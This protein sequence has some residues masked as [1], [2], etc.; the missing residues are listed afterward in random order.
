[1]DVMGYDRFGPYTVFECLGAGGMAS[2]H[3]A[4]VDIGNGVHREIALK[5]LLP[6][7][8]DDKVF[9]EDFVREAKLASLLNH[10]NI[11]RIHELGRIGTTYFI[12]MELVRGVAL[13]QLTKLAIAA[14]TPAPMA[15]TLAIIA[16]L[17]DALDYASSATDH[18]GETL[19]IV[20]RDLS[21]SNVLLTEDGHA[22][23]IDFGVAKA[24]TARFM[25]H[26][27]LVKGKLGYMAPEVLA[28][29]QIDRRAD[30]FSLGVVAWELI[31]GRRLFRGQNE[32]EVIGKIRDGVTDPP[33]LHNPACSAE[34]DEIVLRA[35]ARRADERW[36]SAAV[37]RRA[38]D[39]VRRRH[40]DGP[41]AVLAWKRTLLPDAGEL[42]ETTDM[43]ISTRDMVAAG[44]DPDATELTP[45]QEGSDRI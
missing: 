11:V 10:P 38:L 9:V 4:T 28:G 20:H 8:A 25:T 29:K 33:S 1:M 2:V 22:K 6:Q 39:T 3:R 32:L 45:D 36:P 21:P 35:L 12:A 23:V 15:A 41:G 14:H 24:V 40:R 30:L 13:L 18:Y 19:E 5:R 16:E 27:G 37:M 42:T 17:L 43:Q 26:T 34:L 31:A 44:W 7:F